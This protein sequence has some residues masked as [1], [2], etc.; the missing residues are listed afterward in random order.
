MLSLPA[1]LQLANWSG[2][3]TG[4]CGLQNSFFAVFNLHLLPQLERKMVKN[5]YTSPSASKLKSPNCAMPSLHDCMRQHKL[6]NQFSL[7]AALGLSRQTAIVWLTYMFP[8]NADTADVTMRLVVGVP[9]GV[10][11]LML[12]PLAVREPGTLRCSCK[13]HCCCC[14]LLQILALIHFMC[15]ISTPKNCKALTINKLSVGLMRES[16][17]R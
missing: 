15:S 3:Q 5:V 10:T 2:T 17:A 14:P 16:F 12:R 9:R 11:F 4:I 6:F 1:K 8:P 13:P 7:N